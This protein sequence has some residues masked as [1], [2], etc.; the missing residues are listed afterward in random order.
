MSGFEFEVS[1]ELKKYSDKFPKEFTDDDDDEGGEIDEL[2]WGPLPLHFELYA[3]NG[4]EDFELLTSYKKL[5]WY[6]KDLEGLATFWLVCIFHK[7][8]ILKNNFTPPRNRLFRLSGF[9]IR[10]FIS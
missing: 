1:E 2:E 4:K 10:S 5:Q 3:V 7:A 9:C 8:E 6:P